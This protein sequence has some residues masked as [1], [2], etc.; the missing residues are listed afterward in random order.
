MYVPV[1]T[2]TVVDVIE[3]ALALTPLRNGV[4]TRL[5]GL[6]NEPRFSVVGPKFRL[7]PLSATYRKGACL[8]QYLQS[9]H[10]VLPAL[11]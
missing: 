7:V 2:G 5:Y 8:A 3:A 11:R 1:I 6:E 9:E 10:A 4:T